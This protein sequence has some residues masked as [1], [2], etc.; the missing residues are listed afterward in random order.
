[1][2]PMEE[3]YREYANVVYRYLISLT[4]DND[5]AEELTQ[6]TFYQAIRSSDRYDESCK[7]TTWLCSIARNVLITYRRKH[8]VTEDILDQDIST[9]SAESEALDSL[10]RLELMKKIHYLEDPY[11]E[12]IYLRIFG[13]LS[14]K[15]IGE[16]LGKNENWARVTFYR[17]KEKLGREIEN[18]E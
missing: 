9:S 16:V 12:V 1:M 17:G 18:N 13:E 6:E 8:P 15:E 10:H 4:H 7:M 3:I 11:K 14:F 5:M 2:Q